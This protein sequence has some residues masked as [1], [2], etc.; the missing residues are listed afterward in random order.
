MKLLSTN[1]SGRHQGTSFRI[2]VT[3]IANVLTTFAILAARSDLVSLIIMAGATVYASTT[4]RV[5]TTDLP[6]WQSRLLR[7]VP[8]WAIYVPHLLP[9]GGHCRSPAGAKNSF[10]FVFVFA[11]LLISFGLPGFFFPD[12]I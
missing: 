7:G 6:Q 2:L 8:S 9:Y 5:V 3:C 11:T 4:V 10:I 1:I 12:L